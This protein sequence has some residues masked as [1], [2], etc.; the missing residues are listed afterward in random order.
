MLIILYLKKCCKNL[1]LLKKKKN[2]FIK[3]QMNAF[4]L[5]IHSQNIKWT[6][7]NYWI[8]ILSNSWRWIETYPNQSLNIYILL[9][10]HQFTKNGK[11]FWK[12]PFEMA[13]PRYLMV[14]SRNHRPTIF[15][16]LSSH[17]ALHFIVKVLQPMNEVKCNN[18]SIK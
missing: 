9:P 1:R 13:K 18:W 7:F 2:K 16:P 11:I 17:F 3:V 5:R 15:V 10:K 6:F 8:E 14:F 4:W 12:Y